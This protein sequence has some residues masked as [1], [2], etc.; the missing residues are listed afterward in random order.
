MNKSV[1]VAFASLLMFF[2]ILGVLFWSNNAYEVAKIN[3]AEALNQDDL[4]SPKSGELRRFEGVVVRR[5]YETDQDVMILEIASKDMSIGVSLFPNMGVLKDKYD[6][7]DRV[8]LVGLTDI[9]KKKIQ[10]KPLS[11]TSIKLIDK[12]TQGHWS[13]FPTVKLD[14]VS[15]HTGQTAVIEPVLLTNVKVL[16]SKGKEHVSFQAINDKTKHSGI[17]YEGNWNQADLSLM[18]S[19][20]PLK[21]FVDIDT[22]EDK[23]S[24]ILNG[25]AVSNEKLDVKVN[26]GV[27]E[28]PIIPWNEV[29]KHMGETIFIG[30]VTLTKLEKFKSKAGLEHLRIGLKYGDTEFSGVMYDGVWSQKELT[31]FAAGIPLTMEVKVSDFNNA[32]SLEIQ[33]V[34]KHGDK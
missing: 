2:G 13:L 1:L 12:Q 22:Y 27:K 5:P 6:L 15:N 30:P 20:Q 28:I 33:S 31:F 32:I 17:S 4:D 29:Q 7:G 9:Y 10:L 34:Q 19:G 25:V 18:K 26:D 8:Q 23:P 3:Q 11:K 14:E 24:L 21:L 16:Q